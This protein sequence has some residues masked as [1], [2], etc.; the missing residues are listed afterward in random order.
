MLNVFKGKKEYQITSENQKRIKEEIDNLSTLTDG[1]YSKI[2]EFPMGYYIKIIVDRNK[3]GINLNE[4][5]YLNLPE[6]II[7]LIILDYSFP[8]FPP[9]ILAKTNFFFPNLMDGRNL[10]CSIIPKWN[11]EITLVQIAQILPNFLKKIL[12]STTYCFYGN[13]LIG[14]VYDL[15]NYNNMLVSSFN[16]KV[17]FDS[18]DKFRNNIIFNLNKTE[19]GFTLILCDDCLLLFQN[20]ENDPS[21]GKIIF[22]STLFSITDMQINKEK[23]IIRLNFYSEEKGIE[24]QLKLTME[25]ILF[26]REALVKRMSN[27]KIKIESNK[28]IRGQICEKRLTSKDINKMKINEIEEYIQ[29]LLR[30]IDR[31]EISYYVINTFSVLCGKAIEYYSAKGDDYLDKNKQYLNTMKSVLMRKDVQNIMKEEDE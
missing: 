14:S 22:W 21:F 25:N 20:F 24:K 4:K 2:K 28:L 17:I 10:A 11:K 31:N 5:K 18:D 19:I 30:K 16:C 9:K 6:T 1:L 29:N 7:F 15:K 12:T 3:I 23:K 26:F 8:E 13:F 27:L